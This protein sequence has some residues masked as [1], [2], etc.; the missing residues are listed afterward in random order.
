[1]KTEVTVC[2]INEERVLGEA[3]FVDAFAL[4][5][6]EEGF[7]DIRVTGAEIDIVI[8]IGVFGKGS[9]RGAEVFGFL[10][11]D[12]LLPGMVEDVFLVGAAGERAFVEF[13]KH[14]SSFFAFV[15]A[16]SDVGDDV[17][18]GAIV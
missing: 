17:V 13:E 1:M 4:L 10:I 2:R 11:E 7:A 14:G 16:G 3:V 9:N 15:R 12:D 18:D 5:L 8:G 6:R